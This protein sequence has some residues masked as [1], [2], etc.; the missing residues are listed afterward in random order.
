MLDILLTTKQHADN[1]NHCLCVYDYIE[2]EFRRLML[3]RTSKGF[4]RIFRII[5]EIYIELK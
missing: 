3:F 2:M 5:F 1:I 4:K